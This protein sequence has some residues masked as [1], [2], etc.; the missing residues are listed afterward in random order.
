MKREDIIWDVLKAIALALAVVFLVSLIFVA[1]SAN[2]QTDSS[3]K[4]Q[5]PDGEIRWFGNYI[6]PP[7][8]WQI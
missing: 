8:W 1:I 2:A 4:C 6:C 7:G 5:S 3:V